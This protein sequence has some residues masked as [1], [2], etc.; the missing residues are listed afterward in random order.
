MGQSSQLT[1][2]D[3]HIAAEIA[4]QCRD[5]W[6]DPSAWR[7]HLVVGATRLTGMAVAHYME[8]PVMPSPAKMACRHFDVGWRDQNA[9][10]AYQAAAAAYPNAFDFFPGSKRLLQR[11]KDRSHIVALRSEICSA[12]A[13]YRSAVFNE[14][15]RPAYV[16]DNAMSA[17]RR[18]NGI[19][20]FL[21]VS[22]DLADARPTERTRRQLA[23]LHESIEP[24][25]GLHLATEDQYSM[26]GLAPRLRETLDLLLSGDGERQIAATLGVSAATT[27]EYVA[28]LY[29][30]FNVHS[31]SELM[32][33]FIRRKPM[34]RDGRH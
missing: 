1:M 28:K 26:H 4:N 31:R 21:D 13:W 8:F 15:R 5:L 3:I 16:D 29:R 22:Q 18:Q 17:I 12:D 14:F 23:Y 24:L 34:R 32:A 20:S 19:V 9:R 27:H 30:Y 25:I 33:Y 6:A 2:Q 10:S 11:M 7:Q